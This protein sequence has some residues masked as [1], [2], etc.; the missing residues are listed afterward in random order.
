MLNDYRLPQGWLPAAAINP[1]DA[2]YDVFDL[3]PALLSRFVRVALV[4]GQAEWLDG[5]A[6]TESIQPSQTTS[7]VTQPS[8]IIR[9]AILGRGNMSRTSAG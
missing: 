5:L 3:D 1:A 8:S 2:D 9:K 4:A 6:T 7:L